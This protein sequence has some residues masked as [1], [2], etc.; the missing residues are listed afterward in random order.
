LWPCRIVV[1]SVVYLVQHGEK[2]SAGCGHTTVRRHRHRRPE[3]RHDRLDC[4]PVAAVL[5][6][7]LAGCVT[8]HDVYHRSAALSSGAA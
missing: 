6:Q 4:T 2:A 8:A 3:R 1:M 7:P 5:A